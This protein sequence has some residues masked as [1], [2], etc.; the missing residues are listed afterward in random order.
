MNSVMEFCKCGHPIRVSLNK[1]YKQQYDF[2]TIYYDKWEEDT[3]KIFERFLS[4]KHSYLDV[5]AWIGP[6]V[7]FGAYK[8]KHV[9]AIEPNVLAYQ[10]LKKNIELNQSIRSKITCINAALY[11]SSGEIK[12]FI[13]TDPSESMSSI[14]PTNSNN[15]FMNVKGI[16]L[17]ELISQYSI[18]DVNFVKIDIEGGEYF[19][20]P[21]IREYLE[22]KRPTVYLSI[23][24]PFLLD[25]QKLRTEQEHNTDKDVRYD[26]DLA[27]GLLK[28]L[29]FY[30]YIYD[31]KGNMVDAS[32]VIKE[33]YFRAY[34]F[35]DER[36]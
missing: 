34:V 16:L 17:E 29:D 3:F 30:K 25:A 15:N 13:R 28:A 32:V 10:Q 12:L 33:D 31:L 6:T 22:S 5:G 11:P 7:L 8:A 2:W 18:E 4:P 1:E 24:P 23:H 21:A 9:Y 19:V 26:A 27:N 35:T 14:L 36:W 20:I